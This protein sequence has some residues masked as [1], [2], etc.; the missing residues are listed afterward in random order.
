MVVLALLSAAWV[1]ILW[2]FQ[3][4]KF[5][6]LTGVLVFH[7]DAILTIFCRHG[8]LFHLSMPYWLYILCLWDIT[9]I[10]LQ[11]RHNERNGASNRQRHDCLLSRL[12]WCRSE[13]TSKLRLTGLCE[14]NSPVT[15][16]FRAQRASDAGN[17]YIS[18]RH[19]VWSIFINYII[20]NVWRMLLHD[21]QCNSYHGKSGGNYC[22][23]VE[24]YI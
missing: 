1:S 8:T 4:L 16:E 21:E 14:G 12:F 3:F 23:S 17:I 18:W 7:C 19:Y 9:Y 2:R 20:E 24:I 5:S 10:P 13:K 6:H 15:G 22:S 11:W